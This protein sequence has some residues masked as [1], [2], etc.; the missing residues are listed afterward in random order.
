MLLTEISIIHHLGIVLMLLW[1]LN[2]YYCCHPVVYFVSVIYLYRVNEWY[3]TRMRRELRLGERKQGN[4]RRVLSDSETVRW[5]NHAVEK[6]WP[7]CLEEIVSQYIFLPII[8]WFLAKY[9]PSTV[10]KVVVQDLH[11]GR[12][13]P[14]F[15]EMRVLHQ[16]TD[17]DHLVLELGLNFL[18]ADDMDAILTAEL[19]KRVGF[20]MSANMH[21]TGMH[22]EGKVL[23]GV[24]FLRKWPF[25]GRLRICFDEPPYIQMTVKPIFSHGL[26]VTEIPGI[27]GWLDKLLAI[28]FEE[29]LVEPNMLVVDLEKFVPP[30]P[31]TCFSVDAKELAAYAKV[32]VI[33]GSDMKPSD[34]NG[35]ADPYVKGQLGPYKFRTK[36]QRK[37]LTP[38]W[39]EEFRI[40]ILSWE[41][42]NVLAIKVRD[43]DPFADDNLGVC[44]ININD[45]RDGQRHDMWL[46]LQNIKMGR[47]HLAITIIDADGKG[48]D[49]QGKE[50]M[51]NGEEKANFIGTEIDEKG[52]MISSPVLQNSEKVADSFEA[53]NIEGQKE[54]G[55]WVHHPGSDVSQTWKPR[56]GKSRRLDTQ[57]HRESDLYI[58]KPKSSS[59][60]SNQ[61]GGVKEGAEAHPSNIFQKS[62]QK[63]SSA[64]HRNHRKVDEWSSLGV[65]VPSPHANLKAVNASRIGV[66]VV[67]DT[68]HELPPSAA[69]KSGGLNNEESGPESFGRED[70]KGMGNS[71]TVKHAGRSFKH[72]FR[73]K[74][75]KKNSS[76]SEEEA[77]ERGPDED[78]DSSD[79]DDSLIS[80]VCGPSFEGIPIVSNPITKEEIARSGQSVDHSSK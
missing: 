63:V 16:S 53:I 62:L 30:Q 10:E 40:P 19:G 51:S 32:E 65:S 1:F 33:E 60:G 14:M 66:N 41:S 22:V 72:M 26:D 64:L 76:S 27:A 79:E 36:I 59:K 37:T 2:A 4:L 9:K 6:I 47:L 54:T 77:T 74:G 75:S 7:V 35:L 42:V 56:E 49:H 24:K 15:T 67:V 34:P 20:G 50:K 3:M 18:T 52:P 71:N 58:Y 68:V 5:L 69:T 80:P 57:I 48:M 73:K 78:S 46:P 43:K 25:I 61:K 12:S 17:D 55:I 28:A 44:S 45:L 39:L 23:I 8:P 31:E 29:T 38:N 21:L 13:P 11:L 70:V